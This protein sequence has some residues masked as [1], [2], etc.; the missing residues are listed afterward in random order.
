MVAHGK[1]T[2]ALLPVIL[3]HSDFHGDLFR[4]SVYNYSFQ[5]LHPQPL[6]GEIIAVVCG[7]EHPLPPDI[8]WRDLFLL[9]INVLFL[10]LLLF[11]QVLSACIPWVSK[12]L[13]SIDDETT[14]CF[15][16]GNFCC[17]FSVQK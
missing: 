7:K 12:R 4:C 9:V 5:E 16:V 11:F 10:F 8:F 15:F 14:P 17:L 13:H 6:L 3:P 2:P 1:S